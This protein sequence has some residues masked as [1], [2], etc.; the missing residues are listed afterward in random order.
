MFV[1]NAN[2]IVEQ[3]CTVIDVMGIGCTRYH[4]YDMID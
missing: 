3:V 4:Y 1:C 2:V